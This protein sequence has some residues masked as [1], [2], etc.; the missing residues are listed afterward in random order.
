MGRTSVLRVCVFLALSAGNVMA[1]ADEGATLLSREELAGLIPGT[2]ATYVTKAGSIHRW[3]NEPDG[4][5]VASTDAK[6]VSMSSRLAGTARGTWR[7]SDEG[8]YCINIDWRTGVEDWCQFVFR[9]SDGSYFL[10]GSDRQ[11]GE[12]RPIELQK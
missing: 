4:K 9:A 2:K 11:S 1:S 12:R 6:T 7:I 3:A 10:T 8:R 5:F